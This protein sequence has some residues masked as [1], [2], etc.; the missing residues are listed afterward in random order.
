MKPDSKYI[1]VRSQTNKEAYI[2]DILL[3]EPV[4]YLLGTYS[5]TGKDF[6]TFEGTLHQDKTGRKWGKSFYTLN[7]ELC[8]KRGKKKV[9]ISGVNFTPENPHR[10]FG[11]FEGWAFLAEF[12]PDM[13]NLTLLFFKD[14]AHL[15]GELFQKWQSSELVLSPDVKPIRS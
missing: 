4:R 11:D 7:S 15:A 9:R 13:Q 3:G 14:M 6:I 8:A 12:S 10:T 5:R 2:L 1:F